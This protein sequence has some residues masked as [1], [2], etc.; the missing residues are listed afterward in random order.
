MGTAHQ[1]GNK[2]WSCRASVMEGLT[3]P[4]P[5]HLAFLGGKVADPRTGS[6]VSGLA[7]RFLQPPGLGSS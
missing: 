3:P 6:D 2:E 4:L 5:T 7:L 1:R